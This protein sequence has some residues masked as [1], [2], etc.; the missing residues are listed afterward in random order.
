MD[1][2]DSSRTR[3][4]LAEREI[5]HQFAGKGLEHLAQSIAG[6]RLGNADRGAGVE[7]RV[8]RHRRTGDFCLQMLDVH[9]MLRQHA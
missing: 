5:H 7:E 2:K 8:A 9:L 6:N 4:A 3:L 1:Q